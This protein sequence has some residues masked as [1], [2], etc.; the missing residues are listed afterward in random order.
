MAISWEEVKV[1]AGHN[2]AAGLTAFT[3]EPHTPVIRPAVRYIKGDLTI[4]NKGKLSTQLEW[5]PKVP[6][7]IKTN[8]L[9]VCGLT[10]STFSALATIRLPSN[11]NR[12]TWANYNCTL[13]RPDDDEFVRLGWTGFIIQVLFLEA[14]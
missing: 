7:S 1:A 10:G 2:N 12:A 6:Q 5:V 4:G 11:A 8:V 3:L 9:S 14:I 13:V